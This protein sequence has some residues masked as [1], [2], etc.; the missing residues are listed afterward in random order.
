MQ[1]IYSKKPRAGCSGFAELAAVR[2][3]CPNSLTRQ[4]P[5]AQSSRCFR[6]CLQRNISLCFTCP[7]QTRP[8]VILGYRRRR[9]SCDH[10]NFIVD[11]G[12]SSSAR[13]F[14][15]TWRC[16]LP[17][18]SFTLFASA[19]EFRIALWLTKMLARSWGRGAGEAVV[20]GAAETVGGDRHDGDAGDGGLIQA[21]E[22]CEEVGGGFGEVV[23]AAEP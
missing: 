15:E 16:F 10:G 22:H 9:I 20:D 1:R 21:A 11:K 19:I 7:G 13:A 17:G 2:S 4:R 5:L 23:R 12:G 14:C 8:P 6:C 18:A 3:N